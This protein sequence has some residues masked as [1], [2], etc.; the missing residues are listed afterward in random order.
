MHNKGRLVY[1]SIIMCTHPVINMHIIFSH[2]L[3]NS[4]GSSNSIRKSKYDVD[5]PKHHSP[6]PPP[7]IAAKI[8]SAAIKSATIVG[9]DS[10]HHIDSSANTV[11]DSP[12]SIDS[13]TD[14]EDSDDSG[15]EQVNFKLLLD[16]FS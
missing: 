14:T 8:V 5:Q 2:Y 6:P 12:H 16:S 13:S 11:G 3:A 10:P 1:Q 9:G 15:N 4:T 7:A